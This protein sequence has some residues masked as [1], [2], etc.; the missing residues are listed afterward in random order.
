MFLC[1]R[2]HNYYKLCCIITFRTSRERSYQSSSVASRGQR[3]VTEVGVT[4]A[5]RGD[6]VVVRTGGVV[7]RGLAHET[8]GTEVVIVAETEIPGR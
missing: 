6:A 1:M 2:F 4:G 3:T 8:G 5:G 7:A